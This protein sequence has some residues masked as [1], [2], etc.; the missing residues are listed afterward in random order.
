MTAVRAGRLFDS[1][2]GQ[3]LQRQ[4]IVIA[5]DRIKAVG[6]E[7]RVQCLPARG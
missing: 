1:R 2:A 7:G 3:V 6:P 4:V 5:G